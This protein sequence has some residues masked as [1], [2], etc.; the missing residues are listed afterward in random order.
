MFPI[1]LQKNRTKYSVTELEAFA[2]IWSNKKFL[3]LIHSYQI[4]VITDQELVC[5]VYL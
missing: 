4:E 1:S 2:V 3:Y 5:M